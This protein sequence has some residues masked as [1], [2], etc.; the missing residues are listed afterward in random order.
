ME[1]Y[2]KAWSKVKWFFFGKP[3]LLQKWSPK[4]RPK[5]ENLNSFSIW[6]KIH[7]LSLVCWNSEGISTIAS[8]IGIPLAVDALTAHITRLTFSRVCVQVSA[9]VVFLDEV[10]ISLED[11]VF[12]LKIQYE[13]K[14]SPCEHCKSLAHF[15]SSC[16]SKLEYASIPVTSENTNFWCS[17]SCGQSRSRR[18]HS[19]NPPITPSIPLPNNP[20][21]LHPIP[22]TTPDVASKFTSALP[23]PLNVPPPQQLPSTIIHSQNNAPYGLTIPAPAPPTS[24]DP[25]ASNIPN[26]NSPTDEV[27]SS[28]TNPLPSLTSPPKV[29]SPNKFDTLQL[30]EEDQGTSTTCLLSV[31]DT[32]TFVMDAEVTLPPPSRTQSAK[33]S[34]GKQ[35]RK[36]LTPHR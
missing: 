14:P 24:V 3:F 10:P 21:A 27:S 32:S 22:T 4:L 5:G 31:K 33:S 6:V 35:A 12:S 18:P 13:W 20:A 28:S 2:E 9:N 36:P 7:D 25:P 15:S 17:S 23:Q 34:K 26:L 1:D 30:L 19:H 11:E 16:P 8:K 29:Y